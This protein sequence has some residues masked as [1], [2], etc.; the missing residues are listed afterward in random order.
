MPI[1]NPKKTPIDWKFLLWW[2]LATIGG[3]IIFLI[4]LSPLNWLFMQIAPDPK[5]VPQV[6]SLVFTLINS[7]VMGALFG[8]A[9]WLVLRRVLP[10][11]G[12]W[13]LATALGY[14]LVFGATPL[15]RFVP[16]QLAGSP[17]FLLFGIVLGV[18]QWLVLRRRVRQAAWWIAINMGAWVLAFLLV[19]VVY[20]SGLYVEQFDMLADLLV[21]TI[22]TGI[23]MLWLLRQAPR[24][25]T[26]GGAE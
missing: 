16:S 4:V 18:A 12:G 23:G 22:V 3:A 1:T 7:A 15:L 6:L 5:V 24:L 17:L 2:I 8:L 25:A 9:Q 10:N 13:V 26:I 11:M 20:L 19:G 14:A 21:P